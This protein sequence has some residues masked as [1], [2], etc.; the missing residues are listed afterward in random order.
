M[1][2]NNWMKLLVSC[3]L[4]TSLAAIADE[5]TITITHYEYISLSEACKDYQGAIDKCLSY[6]HEL[7]TENDQLKNDLAKSRKNTEEATKAYGDAVSK[8]ASLPWYV[9]VL[10]GAAAGYIGGRIVK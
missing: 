6:S 7:Q 3:L 9:Y 1:Q 4:V 8:E 10:A 2:K 5:D